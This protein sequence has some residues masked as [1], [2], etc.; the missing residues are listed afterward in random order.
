MKNSMIHL[1]QTKQKTSKRET[2]VVSI[3]S[4]FSRKNH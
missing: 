4:V 2:F 1:T 3:F